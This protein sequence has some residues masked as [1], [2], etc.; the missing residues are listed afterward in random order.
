MLAHAFL[1]VT[2]AIERDTTPT[3]AGLITLPVNEFSATLRRTAAQNP[4]HRRSPP[5]PDHD[6]AEHT[7]TEPDCRITDGANTSGNDR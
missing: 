2:C 5:W 6:G 4:P 1:A 7:N 3:P